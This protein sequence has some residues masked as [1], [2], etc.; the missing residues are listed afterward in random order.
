MSGKISVSIIVP[1][2]NAGEHLRECVDSIL[3]QTLKEIEVILVDDGS[4]DSS[5]KICDEYARRDARVKVLHTENGGPS[6]A[7]NR[8]IEAA[9][10]EFIGFVDADDFVSPLMFASLYNA[11][12]S[13]GSDM[14]FCDYIAQ[15]KDGGVPVRSD[16][17]GDKTYNKKEIETLV[18]PYFFG[19]SSSE[20]K[21]YKSFFPFADYS[22]YVWLCIYKTSIIRESGIYFPDQNTYFNEDHLFNLNFV[23]R[24]SKITHLAKYLYFY[25]DSESSLTKHYFDGF[26]EAKLNRYAYMRDFIRKNGCDPAF[27][28][29]LDNKICVETINIINYYVNADKLTMREKYG[30]IKKTLNSEPIKNAYSAL[31]LKSVPFSK[32]SVFLHLAKRKA[33]RALLLLSLVY[34]RVRRA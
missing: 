26:L 33:C 14:A 2:F 4:T 18:L 16:F 24:A 12:V 8:G 28:R 9:L 19:Y 13:T 5:G 23:Y 29:R 7:R 17:S 6:K 20:L 22:S 31:E 15:K 10:G 11:A 25:R 21:S 34:N 30:K 3:S 27:D 32:L 1:V